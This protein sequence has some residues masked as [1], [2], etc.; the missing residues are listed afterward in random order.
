MMIFLCVLHIVN[1]TSPAIDKGDENEGDEGGSN[2]GK[3]YI[4]IT[5]YV[6]TFSLTFAASSDDPSVPA[7]AIAI[8]VILAV[9]VLIIILIIFLQKRH[10][11]DAMK[12]VEAGR[13][14]ST[15]CMCISSY[16]IMH[17]SYRENL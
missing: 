17:Y 14:Y 16:H 11:K 3:I 7:Y 2:G 13:V 6:H 10:L 9:V 15:L 1:I 4:R 8:I 5:R 12:N